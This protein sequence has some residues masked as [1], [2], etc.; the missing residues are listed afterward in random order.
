V[1]FR[2][3]FITRT[4]PCFSRKNYNIK[5]KDITLLPIG[6][7]ARLER[8]PEKPSEELIVAFAGTF[9]S[10]MLLL[11]LDSLLPLRILQKQLM[12]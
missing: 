6:G 12:A 3:C 7:L 1:H 8:L 10:I 2:Y 5:T 11:S 9:V 4:R